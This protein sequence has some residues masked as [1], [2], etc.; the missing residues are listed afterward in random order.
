MWH[1]EDYNTETW[2]DMLQMIAAR[3]HWTEDPLYE[4]VVGLEIRSRISTAKYRDDQYTPCWNCNERPE[5]EYLTNW[6]K[7]AE[8]AA[9]AV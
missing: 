9:R 1:T 3:Y 4:R 5:Q 2:V 8:R 7:T 6:K